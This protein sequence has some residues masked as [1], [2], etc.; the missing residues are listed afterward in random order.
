MIF[1]FFAPDLK[2]YKHI[3]YYGAF[4]TVKS[5]KEFIKKDIAEIEKMYPKENWID[6]YFIARKIK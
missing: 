6:Y 4:K 3:D 1:V 5:A 2:K